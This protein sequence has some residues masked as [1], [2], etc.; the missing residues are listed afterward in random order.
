MIDGLERGFRAG[1]HAD[2]IGDVFPAYGAGV[3]DEKLRGA[4]D[5]SAAFAALG[6]QDAVLADDLG[7]PIG[8]EGERETLRELQRFIRRVG[9][10]DCNVDVPIAKI[11]GVLIESP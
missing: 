8:K 2:V 3:V 10:D 11:G 4:S 6:M 7:V 1:A 9:A 5:I